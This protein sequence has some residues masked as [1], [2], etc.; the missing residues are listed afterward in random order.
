MLEL[1]DYQP[2]GLWGGFRFRR[3]CRSL[4]SN[5]RNARENAL[6]GGTS[7]VGMSFFS[8]RFG[9]FMVIQHWL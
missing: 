4:E 5:M 9:D 7:T 1:S 6:S 8:G 3:G 2:G